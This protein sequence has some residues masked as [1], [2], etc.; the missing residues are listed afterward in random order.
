MRLVPLPSLA[1]RFSFVF[2]FLVFHVPLPASDQFF[3]RRFGCF[4]FWGLH[5]FQKHRQQ[6][7]FFAG[8]RIW[9]VAAKVSWFRLCEFLA[10][11]FPV[12]VLAHLLRPLLSPA[13]RCTTAFRLVAR[14]TGLLGIWGVPVGA[15]FSRRTNAQGSAV[16]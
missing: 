4:A 13:Y 1:H 9:R 2:F 5:W 6:I 10:E 7:Q 12:E 14:K 15:S 8:V 11:Q 3:F 16:P